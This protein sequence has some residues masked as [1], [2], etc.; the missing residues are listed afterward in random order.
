MSEIVL[1]PCTGPEEWP[2]LVEIWR[3][4]VE[5]THDFLTAGDIDY[6]EGRLIEDY[7]PNLEVTVALADGAIAGFSGIVDGKLEM[8]FVDAERHGGG[9]GTSLLREA[10]EK[11]PGLKVDVNEQNSRAVRFY[12]RHG[13]TVVGRSETD[14]DGR[15]FP[16]LHMAVADAADISLRPGRIEDVP[17]LLGFWAV[18]GENDARPSDSGHLIE[19]LVRRDPEALIVAECGGEIVGTVI[20]G[21]DGWRAHLYRLAVSPEHR[22]R[23]I[24]GKLMRAA[25]ERLRDLG[26]VRF[27]AMVLD[28]NEAGAGA[29]DAMGYE[30][31]ENWT[32]WVKGA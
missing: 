6:Y 15:P 27:D 7:L 29:W 14:A 5:A 2:R 22:R 21:W 30:P 26:A 28:G 17:T 10:M 9:V 23:G 25:E 4:A 31:Q 1:R 16:L 12:A 3:G 20:A 8:L 19:T 11:A 13:L 24:A 18:A 32:R